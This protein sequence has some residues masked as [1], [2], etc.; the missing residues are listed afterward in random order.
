MAVLNLQALV[1]RS[2]AANGND[3]ASMKRTGSTVAAD[4]TSAS[5]YPIC[6][7]TPG[8]PPA[9]TQPKPGHVHDRMDDAI[10]RAGRSGSSWQGS[11]RR[12]GSV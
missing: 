6:D 4:R 5:R 12:R 11:L 9:N 2:V 7:A 8:Y 3:G 1:L 10:G